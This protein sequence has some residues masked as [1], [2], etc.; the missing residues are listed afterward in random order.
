MKKILVFLIVVLLA[1]P[2]FSI[3]QEQLEEAKVT[4]RAM[5]KDLRVMSR[6]IDIAIRGKFSDI[7]LTAG[8]INELKNK[9]ISTKADLQ[10]KFSELP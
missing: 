7:D 3:T 6:A 2:A 1:T 5:Q 9:Y 8:Q 10:T 4:L